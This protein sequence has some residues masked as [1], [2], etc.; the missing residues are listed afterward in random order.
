MPAACSV[1]AQPVGFS[2]V[3]IRTWTERGT[4]SS[5]RRCSACRHGLFQGVALGLPGA[6]EGTAEGHV[7]LGLPEGGIRR[8]PGREA[9]LALLHIGE[10]AFGQRGGKCAWGAQGK[11][12]GEIDLLHLVE[13]AEHGLAAATKTTN[14]VVSSRGPQT[15]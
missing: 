3:P 6:I 11:R 13:S 14:M 9:D 1:P 8:D 5:S 7:E 10:P 4:S 15:R 2:P 12:P